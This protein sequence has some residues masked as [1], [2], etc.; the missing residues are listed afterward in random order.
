MLPEVEERVEQEE[1]TTSKPQ[2]GQNI[3]CVFLTLLEMSDT[4][5][6]A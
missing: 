5:L 6:M 2:Q 3:M 1:K 4:C